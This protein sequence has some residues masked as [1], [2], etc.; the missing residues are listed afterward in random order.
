M[1]PKKA[2]QQ[3]LPKG[4][5]SLQSFFGGGPP[6]TA[7]SANSQATPSPTKSAQKSAHA[8]SPSS[9]PVTEIK[10]KV[11]VRGS[12]QKSVPA[13]KPDPPSSSS[14]YFADKKPPPAATR[15]SN[16]S[17]PLVLDDSDDSDMATA[18]PAAKPATRTAGRAGA[19]RKNLA[20]SSDNDDYD[21]D[22]DDFKP[23]PKKPA[24]ARTVSAAARRSN[25]PARKH[26]DT[27]SEDDFEEIVEKPAAKSKAKPASAAAKSR[28]TPSRATKKE[29]PSTA[30]EIE[31]PT[32]AKAAAKSNWREA[33]A[34]RAAGPVAPGSKEI[35]QGQPNCL[36]GLT[37]VFTGEL[38]SLSRDEA[39]DLAKRY[40]ARI[41]SGPSSKTSYV[42][43]GEGAGA[44]KLESIQKN[45]IKT[46]DEDGFLDLI[47]TRGAGEL[48]EKAKKKIAE[49][50]KKVRETAKAMA[51]AVKEAPEDLSNAL[52]TTKYAPKALK[53]LTGNKSAVE[54]LQT[55]LR[56]WPASYKSNFKKPGPAGMNIYRAVLI[57]GPPGIGKTT[58]A[59]LVAK[60][61]GYTPIEFNASD[62]RSK[63]LIE[64]M[65]RDTIDNKS[66]DGW[67]SGG[68][69]MVGSSD[70]KIT[71]R[72][73]LI[74]DEVDGMSGGDRGGIGAINML[75]KKTKVPIIC[76]CNDRRNQKMRPFEHTTY[77][78]SF[79]KPDAGAVK[80]RMLSIAFREKLKVPGE[81]MGQLIEAAQGD[82]RSVINMLSTWKLGK[83]TMDFDEGKKL[84][85]ENAKPGMHTPFSLYS[86]LSSPYMFGPTCRKTLNDKTELYFQ[87][88]SF[89]PLMVAENY[90]KARPVRA[91]DAD[92]HVSSYK[93]LQLLRHAA[94][95]ISDG[96]MIDRMIHG[97]EQ[98]WSLMPLH[99]IASTVRPCSY[100]YGGT[101]GG[102]PSFPSWLGQ[103]SKQQ[104]LSRAVVDLQARMRL[105]CSGSR[106]DVRQ[107]YL[108]TM[109]PMLIE[110][111][112]ERGSEGIEDVI[113]V[114]D[115]YY[116]G[117]E[118]REA[119]LEL[120]VEPNNAE[121]VIKGI[122]SAVKAGFTRKY[123]STNHPI[124]FYKGVDTGGKAKQLKGEAAP[125][126]EDVVEEDDVPDDVDQ[127][128]EASDDDLSKDKMVKKPKASAAKGK[129]KAAAAAKPK[130]KGKK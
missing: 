113:Q 95:S 9:S 67:Y 51:T 118:D 29:E 50:E 69:R 54:K 10:E 31:E 102:F 117:I 93:H 26:Q 107:H 80:S 18:K 127:E 3:S 125:D 70:V 82:I 2:S 64:S 103:N 129:G 121:T 104:R 47:A 25:I 97:S 19:K 116:L 86:D 1:P 74:M 41:T 100:T 5:A 45:K 76:I 16:R 4:Q 77:N 62:T 122:P 73:V 6:R 55:W 85:L 68:G 128:D 61:E 24:T 28:P 75:I 21:D 112:V 22:A 40:G 8:H 91:R 7:S 53:D 12:P 88:H 89:V 83:D 37:L 78:L 126:L 79:R 27:D 33:A 84:G 14:K 63:K 49:E 13:P 124:A 114:M 81:V 111:L 20:E 32:P 15:G 48:D 123:N 106:H 59:H 130:A 94:E 101:E 39:S 96:D 57:S 87:D 46:L 90:I 105:S 58:S 71:D 108:P 30:S 66:L 35:P 110:P 56:A 92:S 98:H 99:A 23:E 43:L 34:R 44:K 72:T 120:G 11:T 109:W 60:L 38:T 52:W 36:A 42:V 17:D 65:L 115:D 119:I